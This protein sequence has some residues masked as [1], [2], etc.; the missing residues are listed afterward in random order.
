MREIQARN[1]VDSAHAAHVY[2]NSYDNKMANARLGYYLSFFAVWTHVTKLV[3]R[4]KKSK[5]WLHDFY[6]SASQTWADHVLELE[7][8]IERES[9]IDITPSLKSKYD[10][11]TC[12]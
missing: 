3:R 9:D 10:P 7:N 5:C 11:S 8:D 1:Y 12:K 4:N 2:M 6:R